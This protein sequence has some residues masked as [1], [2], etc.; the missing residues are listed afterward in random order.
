VD[1]WKNRDPFFRAEYN[2][3]LQEV[4]ESNKQRLRALVGDAIETVSRVV[5]DD[6]A[7]ALKIIQSCKDLEIVEPPPGPKEVEGV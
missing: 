3:R 5:K 1:R 2:R 7:I 6:A 4:W